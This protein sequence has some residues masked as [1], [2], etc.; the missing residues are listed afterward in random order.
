MKR[1]LLSVTRLFSHPIKIKIL[2]YLLLFGDDS[3]SADFL[4]C[5]FFFAFIWLRLCVSTE[6]TERHGSLKTCQDRH[7]AVICENLKEK[8]LIKQL[9]AESQNL[10][11]AITKWSYTAFSCV[12]CR[13]QVWWMLG[14]AMW[15]SKSAPPHPLCH[16]SDLIYLHLHYSCKDF[17]KIYI[18]VPWWCIWQSCLPV[19]CDIIVK[20]HSS[21]YFFYFYVILH[22][23]FLNSANCQSRK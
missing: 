21:I 11:L 2:P 22:S 13:E 15:S 3:Y 19:A 5:F 1:F 7:C 14:A 18:S 10:P 6:Q 23:L 8:A 20:I 9:L 17:L 4:A 12:V 16:K